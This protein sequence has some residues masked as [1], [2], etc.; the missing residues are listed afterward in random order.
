MR[1]E[2]KLLSLC[3]VCRATLAHKE[4]TTEQDRRL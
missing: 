4:L 2:R 3:G 1:A